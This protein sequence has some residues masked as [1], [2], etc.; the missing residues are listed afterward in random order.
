MEV[1]LKQAVFTW[2]GLS[3]CLTVVLLLGSSAAEI[4]VQ[5]GSGM[6]GTADSQN[7]PPFPELPEGKLLEKLSGRV[8]SRITCQI[9]SEKICRE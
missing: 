5:G 6:Q 9:L 3:I 8:E 2:I 7:L 1:K 4:Q